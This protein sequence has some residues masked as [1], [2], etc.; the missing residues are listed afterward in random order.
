MRV[1]IE[2]SSAVSSLAFGLDALV[3][4]DSENRVGPELPGHTQSTDRRQ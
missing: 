2:E 4:G 1:S 3:A